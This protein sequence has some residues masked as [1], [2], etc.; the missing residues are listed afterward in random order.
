VI[1]KFF[2]DPSSII[3]PFIVLPLLGQILLIVTLFQKK[4]NKI[5]IYVGIFGL[6]LLLGFMFIIGIISLNYKI[7]ISTIPFLIVVALTIINLR[8]SKLAY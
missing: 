2:T 1:Y 3:H 7:T 6:G 8:K 5:L 4:A